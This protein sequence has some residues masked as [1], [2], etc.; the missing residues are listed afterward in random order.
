[1]TISPRASASSSLPATILGWMEKGSL[2]PQWKSPTLT[3]SAFP[4]TRSEISAP[5]GTNSRGRASTTSSRTRIS[6]TSSGVMITV[7]LGQ[8]TASSVSRSSVAGCTRSCSRPA[9]WNVR[10]V[11]LCTP[12]P[13]E[14]IVTRV[15][16]PTIT[17]TALNTVRTL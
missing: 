15:R 8:A 9:L 11:S 6:S 7:R 14:T 4:S 10:T 5:H 3:L 12:T 2:N 1:M 17:P 16:M 13:S